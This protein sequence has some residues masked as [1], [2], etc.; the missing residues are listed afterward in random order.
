[1]E[2]F[3]RARKFVSE[4]FSFETQ[5]TKIYE[6]QSRDDFI[7][8]QKR[9]T[10]TP[11]PEVID[12]LQKLTSLN[13]NQSIS[14]VCPIGSGRFGFVDLITFMDS[15]F[16]IKTLNLDD[17]NDIVNSENLFRE[18]SIQLAIKFEFFLIQ[19]LI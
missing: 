4:S 3:K 1:M 5:E 14:W 7:C 2:L 12:Q 15:F 8:H 19:S 16:A 10:T 11:K 17:F 9:V 13:M 18:I 6:F